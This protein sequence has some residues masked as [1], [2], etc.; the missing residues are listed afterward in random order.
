MSAC[1]TN[2]FCWSLKNKTQRIRQ[3]QFKKNLS[4]TKKKHISKDKK[5]L[6]L[7]NWN[8]NE[9]A[10]HRNPTQVQQTWCHKC[11]AN[12]STSVTSFFRPH[13][14]KGITWTK[15]PKSVISN[16]RW[17]D[18]EDRDR[19]KKS[20]ANTTPKQGQRSFSED[21]GRT[22]H[23]QNAWSKSN[24]TNRLPVFWPTRFDWPF[25]NPFREH[26]R[27]RFGCH[28]SNVNVI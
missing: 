13:F 17:C 6:I 27:K 28:V 14:V 24:T 10:I 11:L 9:E 22:C 26:S 18:H 1:Q 19:P 20:P 25:N 23:Q 12:D 21:I 3:F 15:T 7:A 4:K 5:T 2:D 16:H 8:D